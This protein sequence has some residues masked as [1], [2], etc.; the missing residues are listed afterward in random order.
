MR[1]LDEDIINTHI[2]DVINANKS[3]YW[4]T[5]NTSNRLGYFVGPKYFESKEKVSNIAKFNAIESYDVNYFM[6]YFV[7]IPAIG[8]L[9]NSFIES[10]ESTQ[11]KYNMENYLNNILNKDE[12]IEIN[13]IIQELS[14]NQL[15]SLSEGLNDIND[16]EFSNFYK[17]LVSFKRLIE[18][19]KIFG[20]KKIE[21]KDLESIIQQTVI[22][23][24]NKNKDFINGILNTRNNKESLSILNKLSFEDIYSLFLNTSNFFNK[25]GVNKVVWDLTQGFLN[26]VDKVMDAFGDG[27]NA[28]SDLAGLFSKDK[29]KSN[30]ND[31]KLSVSL[32]KKTAEI[33]SKLHK[34]N[35]DVLKALGMQDYR[36]KERAG[37]IVIMKAISTVWSLGKIM[38]FISLKT[39]EAKL[40]SNQSLYYFEPTIKIPFTDITFGGSVQDQEIKTLIDTPLKYFNPKNNGKEINE[41]YEFNG[42][43]YHEKSKAIKDLKY[44]IFKKPEDYLK[45][46]KILTSV[47]SKDNTYK[48]NLPQVC[49]G[50]EKQKDCISNYEYNRRFAQEKEKF[51]ENLFNRFYEN[52]KKEYFLDGFGGAHTS[53]EIAMNEL[54]RKADKVENYKRVYIYMLNNNRVIKN[55]LEDIKEFI[56]NNQPLEY[57]NIINTDLIK[58]NHFDSLKEN[59]NYTFDIWKV[60]FY[61][62][63]K[64]FRSQLELWK[65]LE[66]KLNYKVMNYTREETTHVYNNIEFIKKE[67][68][69]NWINNQIVEVRKQKI[70]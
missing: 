56:R 25:G 17:L 41:L 19:S 68:F 33:W 7:A 65:F 38:S 54:K 32:K 30:K 29:K 70:N 2:K 34:K 26:K 60:N 58:T 9:I 16:P 31:K 5:Q 24:L 14:L 39:Y 53:K 59:N 40:D 51:I 57:K 63:E 46:K 13:S 8:L 10:K 49:N 6:S 48:L 69:I 15:D 67:E 47:I 44:E 1:D 42:K 50:D 55:R 37:P 11:K 28:A 61:G 64:Y 23:I 43:Y 22:S 18:I 36:T 21:T 45:T 20:I 3:S 4:V 27:V 12:T 66:N 35:E 62:Q 52:S